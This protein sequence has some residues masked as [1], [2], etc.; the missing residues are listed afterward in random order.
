MAL[1]TR[2]AGRTLI[3]PVLVVA[4]EGWI[5]A[6]LGAA[7]AV[8][9]LLETSPTELIAAFDTDALI[10]YRSRRPTLRIAD[11]VHD[12]TR[13]PTIELRAGRDRAGRDFCLLVGA[14]PDLRW[15]AFVAEVVGLA[16]ELGVRLAVGLGAFPAPVP[17]TRPVKVA[18]TAPPES[19]HLLARVGVVRATI[20]VPAGAWGA[21]EE[22]FGAAALPAVG[23]WARV[24]HY[25]AGMPFPPASAA[26]LETLGRVA[27]LELDLTEVRQAGDR[28]LRRVDELIAKSRDH[29]EMVRELERTIDEAE[30]NPLRVSRIPTGDEIAAELERYLRQQRGE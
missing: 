17:H 12:R 10:D 18:A 22:A 2:H 5:D 21:L 1:H 23:L 3:D 14:E 27:D 20:E 4:L 24:P 7:G 25:V 13:W 11:G 8:A 26:L 16:A 28:T 9:A 29:A 19:E 6:G 15:R 30:G